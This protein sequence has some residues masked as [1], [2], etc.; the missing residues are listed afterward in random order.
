MGTLNEKE[1]SVTV[2]VQGW[3]VQVT[4][5]FQEVDIAKTNTENL[6]VDFEKAQEYQ[7]WMKKNPGNYPYIILEEDETAMVEYYKIID[8]AHRIK[9]LQLNNEQKVNAVFVIKHYE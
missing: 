7:Q 3:K 6:I 5:Y 8:G 1:K 4:E 9:A 2:E